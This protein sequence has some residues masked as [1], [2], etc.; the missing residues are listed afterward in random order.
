MSLINDALKDL[1]RRSVAAA[2]RARTSGYEAPSRNRSG[3]MFFVK[4]L[5]IVG[6]FAVGYF[7]ASP[8]KENIVELV[9]EPAPS[10]ENRVGELQHYIVE[11]ESEQHVELRPQTVIAMQDSNY[12]T[13]VPHQDDSFRLPETRGQVDHAQRFTA[14]F[15]SA[16]L[17]TS[18]DKADKIRALLSNAHSAFSNNRLSIPESDNAIYFYREVLALEPENETAQLGLIRVK[19]RYFTLI[20]TAI[21]GDKFSRAQQ[22]ISRVRPLSDSA[23]IDVLISRLSAARKPREPAENIANIEKAKGQQATIQKSV[24]QI[25]YDMFTRARSAYEEGNL[26]SAIATMEYFSETYGE[27]QDRSVRLLF[28]AYVRKNNFSK[29]LLLVDAQSASGKEFDDL[30]ARILRL[31]SGDEAARVYLE[32]Q[33]TL[34]LE[35]QSLLAAY[36]QKSEEFESAQKLYRSLVQRDESNSR[37]WLG[38]AVSSDSLSD[39]ET[40]RKAYLTSRSLGG[41][42]V[43]I[44]TFINTRLNELQGTEAQAMELSRW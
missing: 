25:E 41:H 36:Y 2:T 4:G 23:E 10:I 35:A 38:L 21:S 6:V 40:A 37:Y 9:S 8:N 19:D 26:G 44:L 11:Q 3:R 5:L 43:K 20:N 24:Q 34:S 12:S 15:E 28:N 33:E 31:T 22:L 7:V 30:R 1:D 17:V 39:S 16:S 27:M 29:A 32:R 42:S 13:A 14:E 18:D